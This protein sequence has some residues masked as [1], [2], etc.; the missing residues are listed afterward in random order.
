MGDTDSVVYC[1]RCT[2]NFHMWHVITAG[3]RGPV[4]FFAWGP[5]RCV[6]HVHYIPQFLKLKGKVSISQK[7]WFIF[8]YLHCMEK[9]AGTLF[10]RFCLCTV[11]INKMNITEIPGK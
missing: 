4:A 7:I 11:W 6:V 5:Q 9:A 10:Q 1:S 8:L 3:G 2:I